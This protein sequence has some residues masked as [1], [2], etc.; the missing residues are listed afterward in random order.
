MENACSLEAAFPMVG[1]VLRNSKP[2]ALILTRWHQTITSVSH[3]QYMSMSL[4][5]TALLFFL[6]PGIKFCFWR[7]VGLR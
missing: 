5:P 7:T 4:F 1:K 3:Q 2:I 6:K